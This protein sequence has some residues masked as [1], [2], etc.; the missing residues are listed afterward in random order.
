MIFGGGNPATAST[1]IIDLSQSPPHW[2][3]GP[4]MSQSRIEM[5]ATILPNGKVLATGGSLNDE[6][7]ATASFN[8]DL[9]DPATNSFSSAGTVALFGG[10]PQRGTYEA[11]IE[12]Y[13]PAYLF[14][15]DGS[16]A[17]RPVITDVTAG[18]LAYGA[19]FQV[20]T[21]DAS[22]IA[23]VV[24]VRAGAPTHAFDM[25]QRLVELSYSIGTG[26]LNVTAPPNGNVAPPGYYMLF[27]LNAAGVPSVARFVQVMHVSTT[28]PTIT[29]AASAT[30]TVG[31]AGAF[32]VTT[33]GNPTPALS[34][35]GA[36][37]SGVTFVNNG[38]GTATLSGTP[39]SGTAGTYPITITANNGVTPSATQN[40]TLTVSSGGGGGG[41]IAYVTASVTGVVDFGG[42]TG[43]TL[44]VALHQAPAAGHLVVCAATWQSATATA[45]MSD[46]N[47]GTWTPI[48]S[49][50]T[51]AGSLSGYRGQMFYVPAAANAATTVTL[52][53]ST[54]VPF[55]AFECA[56]YSYTGTLALD[57][58]PVYSTTP[59]SAGVATVSGLT[60][61]KAN[62]LVFADC[63]GVD[64]KCTAGTGFTGLDDPNSIFKD[65]ATTGSFFSG[66]GQLIEF[67]V[68]VAAGAQSATFNTGTNDNVILGLVAFTST[69]GQ[70]A[71]TI[72]SANT[73][74]F[75]VGTAGT[76]TVTATGTP[77]PSLTETGAL[78]SGVT[79]V[80]NGN[81][82]A[83][84]SGTPAAGAA[85][86]YSLTVTATNG[87]GS[88]A[89]QPFTL[90]VQNS[91]APAI[92]SA[93]T[94]TFGVG[95]AGNFTVTATGTPTPSL[96]E[97]GALPSGVTFVNNGNG[98]ATL[99]GIPASGA[100]G[101]YPIT[102]TANNGVAPSGTQSFTLS[103][104]S[105]GGGG[106]AN[107]AYVT[108]SV[109]GVVDFGSDTGATLSVT[110][111]QAP[112]AGHL[113]VCAATWQSATAT[114]AMSDPNNGTWTPIGSPRTGVGS[115]SGYRG[116]LFYLPAAANG[117]TTVTLTLSSAVAFRA[118]ECAEYSYTG[119]ISMLDGVPQYSSTPA[120]NGTATVSG[121]TTT[122][123]SD[124]VFADCL[125]VD[126]TCTAGTG[127][128]GLDDP[129]TIFKD[130]GTS[131]SFLSGTGQLLEFKV[132]VAPGA[133]SAT[134][135]TG[136]NDNVIL[137]LVAF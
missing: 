128:T 117:A 62:D 71:P 129:N 73:A 89:N 35:T 24:L 133:Q 65:Q 40:F 114:A 27:V 87:V 137:G 46:P 3:Y 59:A 119:T 12:I 76:F 107:F 68:G 127:F 29:S 45:A 21:P 63:L 79:F 36:L 53:L 52:T 64:T 132:G 18:P 88:P 54:A 83:T 72:T 134:Y 103:V 118:F 90:T 58:T 60:T 61:T 81:G 123:P 91:Q 23:S 30:F 106:P 113:V 82:T 34:E 131:G 25:D 84:L 108:G 115:L 101:T 125:G 122:N 8:A 105:G 20:T 85:G 94:A 70:Q 16:A 2:Q 74:T 100:A 5:N 42:D 38:N 121:L 78:P 51:G 93:N 44:S 31:T 126:T 43:A 50:R 48:G 17:Q 32:T 37:P 95:T 7:A 116:Q 28:A 104:S 80:N 102:I 86:T 112:A 4:P 47:N 26:V 124:L 13:S 96:S 92:T 11:R 19:G 97:T 41:N 111:H 49:P 22:T 6:D 9:Y 77:M 66:T 110:L 136:T 57:G 130:Q 120:A 10:N 69:S 39:A 1:E 56:E 75:G 15:A 14:N 135:K 33:T 109:T 98:T 55:R 67:K 99:S